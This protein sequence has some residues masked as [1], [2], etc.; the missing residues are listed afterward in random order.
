MKPSKSAHAK[1]L[2]RGRRSKFN[3]AIQ[4]AICNAIRGGLGQDEAAIINNI[5]RHTLQRWK[6]KNAPFCAA[7]E[8]AWT[9]FEQDQ[10]TIIREASVNR[11][12]NDGLI[13]RRGS[14]QAA[15]W[16]A[17]RRLGEKYALK[18]QGSLSGPGGKPLIP[19]APGVDTS[20]FTKEQLDKL[21]DATAIVQTLAIEAT[22]VK[23]EPHA[24]NGNGNGAP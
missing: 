21:I 12:S 2:S 23:S 1:K 18:W 14:W 4:E 8:R 22:V 10:L 9:Q 11:Y 24:T 6:K 20:R 5:D 3:K 15:A 16:L 17:E 13:T 19:E 7:L